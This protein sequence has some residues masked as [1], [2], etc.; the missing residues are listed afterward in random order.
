M[1]ASVRSGEGTLATSTSPPYAPPPPSLPPPS[2]GSAAVEGA[3]KA[4]CAAAAALSNPSR[5]PP[6]RAACHS[7]LPLLASSLLRFL[8]RKSQ[9]QSSAAASSTQLLSTSNE[10]SHTPS[11]SMAVLTSTLS[12]HPPLPLLP[13]PCRSPLV[14]PCR[15]FLLTTLIH[16]HHFNFSLLPSP[17]TYIHLSLPTPSLPRLVPSRPSPERTSPS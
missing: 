2:A 1:I 8:W 5:P 4:C 6:D 11:L 7:R 12:A 3:L 13:A 14:S 16:T 9:N 17:L 10:A 15:A